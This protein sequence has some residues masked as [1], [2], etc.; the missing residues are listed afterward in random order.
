MEQYLQVITT[1]AT[2]ADAEKIA[3]DL[4]E[5]RLAACVQIV[6]PVQSTYRWNGKI[7]QTVEWQCL[8]KSRQDLFC[9]VEQAIREIHPYETPEIIAVAIVA[10]SNDYRQWL[11]D[12]LQ[13]S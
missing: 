4:V 8:I 6:G 10:G 3:A 12:E 7:E 1:T 9:D 13:S 5:K 2:R 11:R